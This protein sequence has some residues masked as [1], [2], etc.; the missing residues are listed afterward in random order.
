MNLSVGKLSIVMVM[1]IMVQRLSRR[2]GRVADRARLESVFR[3]IPNAGSNP[4]L[5]A[6]Y[7]N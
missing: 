6:I 2:G 5:S 3:L 7:L 4:A 1:T